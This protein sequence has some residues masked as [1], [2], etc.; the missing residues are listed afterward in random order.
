MT[1]AMA[2]KIEKHVVSYDKDQVIIAEGSAPNSEL[3]FL[4]KGTAVAEM[5]GKVVGTIRNG[6]W[7]GELASILGIVRTATVRAMSKCEV[8]RFRGLDDGDLNEVMHRDPKLIRKLIEQ[9]ATR[10][11]ETS[12]RHAEEMHQLN[13]RIGRLTGAVSG[14]IFALEKL[15]EKFKSKVMIEVMDHLKGKS[16]VVSGEAAQ[17]DPQYFQQSK[18][19]IWG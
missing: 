5:K 10:V 7:F 9:L 18:N 1:G 15:S 2:G 13:D 11:K 17:A 16:G 6:E 12:S 3:F 19:A 8:L 14:T 4:T